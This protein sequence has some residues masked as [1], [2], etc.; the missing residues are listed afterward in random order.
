MFKISSGECLINLVMSSPCFFKNEVEAFTPQT[1]AYFN[2]VVIL[3]GPASPIIISVFLIFSAC[4][5]VFLI[6]SLVSEADKE[7][8]VT[9]EI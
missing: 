8:C 9:I 7:N 2:N 6:Q 4:F 1:F 5:L 3:E